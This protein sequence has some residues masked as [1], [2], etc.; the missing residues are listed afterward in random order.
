MY[1][2]FWLVNFKYYPGMYLETPKEVAKTQG[3][4]LIAP[5]GLETSAFRY[6]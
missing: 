6:D 2:A 1:A 4:S 3:Y 5:V